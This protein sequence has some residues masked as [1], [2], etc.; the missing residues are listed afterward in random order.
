M[1]QILPI[2]GIS[3][4]EITQ[5][6]N[7]IRQSAGRSPVSQGSTCPTSVTPPPQSCGDVRPYAVNQGCNNVA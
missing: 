1:S 2:C 4:V 7:M 5:F 3:I 6:S